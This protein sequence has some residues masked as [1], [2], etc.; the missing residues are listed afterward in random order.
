M[1]RVRYHGWKQY[2]PNEVFS[3]NY[4]PLTV[5][6]VSRV[7]NYRINSKSSENM[8]ER[9]YIRKFE[10]SVKI[11][12]LRHFSNTYSFFDTNIEY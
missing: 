9:R 2:K 10:G 4:Y 11:V 6:D 7:E 12:T 1:Y 8:Y 3:T 5:S